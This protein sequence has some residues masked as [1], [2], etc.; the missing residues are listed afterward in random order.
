[1]SNT[2]KIIIA[3]S[4]AVFIILAVLFISFGLPFFS[5]SKILKARVAEF[6]SINNGDTLQISDPHNSDVST[7]PKAVDIFLTGDEA[8]ALVSELLGVIKGARYVGKDTNIHGFWDISVSLRA[9]NGITSVYLCEDEI[10]VTD[11]TSKY[12]FKPKN[13]AEY[14]V[15]YKKISNMIYEEAN[16]THDS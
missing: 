9:S 10:Y 15:F 2:K 7:L 1:M 3:A 16:S 12:S 14:S 4:V 5:A 8:D 6:E 13:D 11:S